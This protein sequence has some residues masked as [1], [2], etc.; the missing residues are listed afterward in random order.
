M[1]RFDFNDLETKQILTQFRKDF[2]SGGNAHKYRGAL[3][4]LPGQKPINR[5]Q[6]RSLASINRKQ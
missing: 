1:S 5:K 2:V 3:C 6:R 4:M